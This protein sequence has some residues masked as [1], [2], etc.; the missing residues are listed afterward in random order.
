MVTPKHF[1]KKQSRLQPC[2]GCI[3]SS[4]DKL[5]NLTTS[6]NPFQLRKQV[7]IC[8][9]QND[10]DCLDTILHIDL[11]RYD[12]INGSSSWYSTRYTKQYWRHTHVHNKPL[13]AIS[14]VGRIAKILVTEYMIKYLSTRNPEAHF[15]NEFVSAVELKWFASQWQHKD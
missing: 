2:E 15:F 5:Q 6:Q 14:R 8:G 1:I 12:L 4:E 7:W 9:W 3:N 10:V 11:R 13:A